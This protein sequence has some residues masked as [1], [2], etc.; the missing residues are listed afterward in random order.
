MGESDYCIVSQ[1]QDWAL[2]RRWGFSED[3][4]QVCVLALWVPRKLDEVF[5]AEA[6]AWVK[7]WGW[8]LVYLRA[9]R[10]LGGEWEV[11]LEKVGSEGQW[12]SNP[13][14]QLFPFSE[15]G[16]HWRFGTKDSV[17][18]FK[19]SKNLLASLLYMRLG[20]RQEGQLA[21]L[22]MTGEGWG[23]LKQRGWSKA[24]N[25]QPFEG[26]AVKVSWLIGCRSPKKERSCQ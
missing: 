8:E 24:L 22:S 5:Q 25:G 17:L 1:A 10:M 11:E 18:W 14:C 7:V 21:G 2:L 13:G 12:G 4:Y 23:W 9:I 3:L 6:I 26:K 20:Q 15:L 16:S 19:L